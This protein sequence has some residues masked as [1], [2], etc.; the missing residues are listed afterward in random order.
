MWELVIWK[1]SEER[2]MEIVFKN[3]RDKIMKQKN[4]LA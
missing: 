4:L 1:T 3:R 2:R